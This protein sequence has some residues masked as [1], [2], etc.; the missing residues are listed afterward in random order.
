MQN[1]PV[2][3]RVALPIERIKRAGVAVR[4]APAALAAR[5]EQV[6]GDVEAADRR[7]CAAVEL[8][9][10]GEEMRAGGQIERLRQ[11]PDRLLEQL[12]RQGAVGSR[13]VDAVAEIGERVGG[14]RVAELGARALAVGD[15]DDQDSIELAARRGGVVGRIGD[16]RNRDRRRLRHGDRLR[17]HQARRLPAGDNQ[18]D[19]EQR[20]Q[21]RP[22]AAL[23]PEGEDEVAPSQR[24]VLGCRVAHIARVE[25]QAPGKRLPGRARIADEKGE[26]V[27][28]TVVR[29]VRP[30]DAP[31]AVAVA[32]VAP[33]FE[34][35]LRLDRDRQQI[36]PGLGFAKTFGDAGVAR[37]HR[38]ARQ[39]PGEQ[40][41]RR[42]GV[43]GLGALRIGAVA[44]VEQPFEA[45]DCL[46]SPRL[47]RFA[48]DAPVIAQDR[49]ALGWSRR[50]E[51][52]EGRV[53]PALRD[54]VHRRERDR[55]ARAVRQARAGDA[56]IG[57]WV[58]RRRLDAHRLG[59]PFDRFGVDRSAEQRPKPLRAGD[60]GVQRLQHA[61]GQRL[62]V[63]HS[64]RR[65]QSQSC[66]CAG[67][68]Q[69]PRRRLEVVV[70]GLGGRQPSCDPRP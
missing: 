32:E 14:R 25:A 64:R 30:A 10:D 35:L 58:D 69:A 41:G 20:R 65:P 28:E 4:D 42:L 52:R 50:R 18:G 6:G 44:L 37:G 2:G 15:E 38:R 54:R 43:A 36:G 53:G 8:R 49:Q 68:V 39:V 47:W 24:R 55:P 40:V 3:R 16:R 45:V 62:G 13:M 66:R 33:G 5:S 70:P 61:R 19:G 29:C 63:D 22:Q 1:P 21:L 17:A 31:A 59:D 11:A 46:S 26:N 9:L 7:D 56:D 27:V 23:P 67:V 60:A 12:G 57:E 48:V 34:G 51:R